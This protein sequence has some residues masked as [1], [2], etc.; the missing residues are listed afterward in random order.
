MTMT[1]NLTCLLTGG[2]K[3]QTEYYIVQSSL[4]KANQV[5]TG[6]TW[7]L[8]CFCIVSAELLLK[9]TIDELCLLL[10]LQ[11]HAILANLTTSAARLTL[12][13][14]AEA[15]NAWLNTE[16]TASLQCWYSI[17]CHLFCTSH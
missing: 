4:Q 7:H 11:L 1:N 13:T 17:N 10:F 2:S 5:I 9:Y 12:G 3:A 14:L 16:R 15:Y 6:D 8:L